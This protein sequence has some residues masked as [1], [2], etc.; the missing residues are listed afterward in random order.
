M[1]RVDV[2]IPCYN[3]GRFLRE[4]VESVLAQPLQ[5]LRVHVI[6]DASQDETPD[7][8]A[9]LVARDNRVAYTRH[10]QNRG[11]IATYNEGLLDWASAD[12]SLLLS[13]DDYLL[14]GALPQAIGLMDGHPEIGFTFGQVL[15]LDPGSAA[16]PMQDDAP[17]PR[18]L[19]GAQF[20]EMSGAHALVPPA[21]AVVRTEWQQRLGGYRADLPHAGDMEMWLRFAAHGSVGMF[22]HPQAVYRRHEQNM[23]LSYASHQ[24]PALREFEQRA[25]AFA[26]FFAG[27]AQ[28]LPDLQRLR[29][30]TVGALAKEAVWEAHIAFEAGRLDDC[31][32]LADFA[33]ELYPPVMRS[34]GWAT[35]AVKRRLGAQAWAA[36]RP[37]VAALRRRPREMAAG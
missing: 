33:G 31:R 7:V 9:H 2:V 3:Y 17:P 25:C 27:P 8:A 35:L 14:P 4:C 28:R 29:A 34:R 10:A 23:S 19:S 30:H 36:L 6:D 15:V 13:A 21:T 5:E 32:A 1:S 37:A 12:Y 22:A 18:I 16:G 11:H 20:V 24:R 26:A